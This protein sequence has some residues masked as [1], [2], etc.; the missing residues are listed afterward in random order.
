MSKLLTLADFS[1]LAARD[2]PDTPDGR[3]PYQI[4]PKVT[5]GV[6]GASEALHS[7]LTFFVD[8]IKSLRKQGPILKDPEQTLVR[9]CL[10]GCLAFCTHVKQKAFLQAVENP[11]AIDDRQGFFC[12]A[13]SALCKV[14]PTSALAQDANNKVIE[15]LYHSLPHPPATYLAPFPAQS[16]PQEQNGGRFRSAD[17]GG[18]NVWMPSLG[19][20]GMPYARDVENKHPLPANVLPDPGLVFDTLLR[21]KPGN[22][23]PHPGGNS[24][25]TFAFASLVTHSLFRTNPRN[26]TINDTNSYLDLSVLYGV[27]SQQQDM[28]RNKDEGRGYLWKDAFAEDRLVLVPPAASALLVVFSRNHNVGSFRFS[29]SVTIL[30]VV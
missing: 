23:K 28:I 25:L 20:A 30:M 21:A 12:E 17:G 6:D 9:S 10:R 26:W 4:Q 8:S 16:P 13:L 14:P 27:S 11:N 22:F 7:K 19:R 18:N 1:H 24:S 3:Y 5:G 15:M 29:I 2:L